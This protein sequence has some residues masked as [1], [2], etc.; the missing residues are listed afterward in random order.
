MI[1]ISPGIQ[2]F[3]GVGKWIVIGLRIGLRL[4]PRWDR[5][6]ERHRDEY[7]GLI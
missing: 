6:R 1:C 5:Y 7:M 3:V 2:M 4:G